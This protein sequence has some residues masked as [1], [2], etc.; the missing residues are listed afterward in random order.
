MAKDGMKRRAFFSAD[1]TY[2]AVL[3]RFNKEAIDFVKKIQEVK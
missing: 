2:A 1:P 3:G